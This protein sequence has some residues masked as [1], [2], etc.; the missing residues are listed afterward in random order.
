MIEIR[1]INRSSK[2]LNRHLDMLF[3]N[4][5]EGLLLFN[6]KYAIEDYNQSALEILDLPE[7]ELGDLSFHSMEKAL[8]LQKIGPSE[9]STHP[10]IQTLLAGKKYKS[11]AATWKTKEGFIKNLQM[12]MIPLHQNPNSTPSHILMTFS[13]VTEQVKL[14]HGLK[15]AHSELKKIIN[16][17]SEGLLALDS[18]GKVIE[19]NNSAL[20]FLGLKSEDIL[21]VNYHSFDWKAVREDETPY[22]KGMTP[23]RT[24]V[25]ENRPQHGVLA[26]MTNMKDEFLWLSVDA[27]PI[28][29]ENE[30]KPGVL[31]TLL[32]VT[33][34]VRLQKR[35]Q[36]ELTLRQ[37]I[38]DSAGYLVIAT[39]PNGIITTF[40]ATAEKTLGYKAQEVIGTK[41]PRIFH[42]PFEIAVRADELA[43]KLN[44]NVDADFEV[45]SLNA[46]IFGRYEHEWTMTRKDGTQFPAF[47][48]MTTLKNTKGDITGYLGISH[49]LTEEKKL[50]DSLERQRLSMAS[51]SKMAALGE[52]AGGIAHEI[53]NPLT[54]IYGKADHLYRQIQ[55]DAFPKERVLED[56]Q[57]IKLTS[58]RIAKIVK[59]LRTFSRSGEN[60]PFQRVLIDSLI[61]ET[62]AFCSER[63][64]NQGVALEVTPTPGLE[65]ECR[66]TQLSQVLLNLLNN[67]FDAVCNLPEKWVKLDVAILPMDQVQIS[68]TDSGG[69]IPGYILDKLMQP[70]FTTKEVG[71]GTGL[72]LSVSQGIIQDHFGS[73][74]VDKKCKNTR[75][76]ITLPLRHKKQQEAA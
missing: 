49:D 14:E 34:R 67:A 32:N 5:N 76:L 50:K 59:G 63:F 11:Q 30:D 43:T 42:D 57:K 45:F 69:G 19:I 18:S 60:D 38:L 64:R 74:E 9:S 72:G 27:I 23:I 48:S 62:L 36:N 6:N 8:S 3:Q 2:K 58:E 46:Q 52:M 28:H 31:V 55:K 7:S 26:G 61:S 40:N 73:L 15:T 68:I 66:S 47:L 33:E 10:L 22:E 51:T 35:F 70:F 65:I 12:N 37:E 41:S 13:D 53:N 44:I 71:K 25:R 56:I 20:N 29:R 24:A 54:I 39:D 17:M 1:H 4:M 75:F 16:T 21:G